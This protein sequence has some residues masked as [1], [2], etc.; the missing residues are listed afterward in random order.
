VEDL[1]AEDRQEDAVGIDAELLN[2][3]VG[4]NEIE[5]VNSV[6]HNSPN[7]DDVPRLRIAARTLA[8][9]NVH[10]DRSLL[11][12]AACRMAME[13]LSL[14]RNDLGEAK[15]SPCVPIRDDP[16]DPMPHAKSP[17]NDGSRRT[18]RLR[19]AVRPTVGPVHS[20]ADRALS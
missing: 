1:R 11:K 13:E 14:F 20:E 18:S 6:F 5:V 15:T 17:V 10:I 7:R 3:A 12:D 16:P 4:A 8:A 2:R 19:F 9:R